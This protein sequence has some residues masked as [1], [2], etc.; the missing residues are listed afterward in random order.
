MY[1]YNKTFSL[2]DDLW[3]VFEFVLN[4]CFLWDTVTLTLL[5]DNWPDLKKRKS[6][7]KWLTNE[8]YAL[9]DVCSHFQF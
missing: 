2:T 9:I 3:F 1:V 7:L 8:V 4:I 6:Q 5:Y